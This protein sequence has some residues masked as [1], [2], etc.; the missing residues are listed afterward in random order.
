VEDLARDGPD[1]RF[2]E[3]AADSACQTPLVTV[4]MAHRE[5]GRDGR[6]GTTGRPNLLDRLIAK[7]TT[8]PRVALSGGRNGQ[9]HKLPRTA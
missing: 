3:A 2:F 7:G 9:D 8:L 1:G 5:P 4:W 6:S